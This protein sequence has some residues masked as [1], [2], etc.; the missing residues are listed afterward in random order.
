M[1]GPP[2]PRAGPVAQRPILRP[3][4][5]VGDGEGDVPQA[6]VRDVVERRRQAPT[7]GGDF[8]VIWVLKFCG[9]F[10]NFAEMLRSVAI[11][12][13]HFCRD[14]GKFKVKLRPKKILRSQHQKI[15]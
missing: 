9:I 14:L 12:R 13:S 8:A 2:H 1:T 4:E 7:A 10:R 5:E 6:V 11:L 3:E 15:F